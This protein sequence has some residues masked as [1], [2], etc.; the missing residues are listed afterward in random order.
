MPPPDA[1][2]PRPKGLRLYRELQRAIPG[3]EAMYALACAT[4]SAR[5]PPGG[6]ILV[7]GAGGGQELAGFGAGQHPLAITA[8]DPS[9]ERLAMAQPAAE[10]AGLSD[11]VELLATRVEDLA[12]QTPFAA[13]SSLLVM[14]QIDDDGGKLAYLSAIRQRLAD[15]GVLVH[16]DVC[17]DG[18]EE[19]AALAPGFLHHA[20]L[21]GIDAAATLFELE[22][23]ARLP[24]VSA[25]RTRELFSEAG[26]GSPREVFR[27]LWYRCWLAVG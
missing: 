13:A 21:A 5:V 8:I 3:L 11:P 9:S 15:R 23:L 10:E 6:R 1:A 24:I 25:A 4:I 22:A 7:V 16:A 27:S 26:F 19:L 17:L 20:A 2:A 18:P 14:H 12:I